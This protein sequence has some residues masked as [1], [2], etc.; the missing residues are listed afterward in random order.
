MG[1][2]RDL[3]E[4]KSPE[5]VE[6][7][8]K[9]LKAMR[10]TLHEKKTTPRLKYDGNLDFL[11]LADVIYVLLEI[12]WGQTDEEKI[13]FI[14]EDPRRLSPKN[15]KFPT[16]AFQLEK[17]EP[18]VT[19]NRQTVERTPRERERKVIVNKNT[20]EKK[21]VRIDGQY[22]DSEVSFTVFGKSNLE[23]MYYSK[24]F[25][26]AMHEYKGLLMSHGVQNMWF[27]R[28]EVYENKSKEYLSARKITYHVRFE[29]LYEVRSSQ[30]EEIIVEAET[31]LGKL[32]K[33]GKLPS[34]N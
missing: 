12:I 13:N 22:I 20:G 9:D 32:R 6:L 25:M 8:Q 14:M 30:V 26:E 3:G 28:D 34:Q 31:V 4:L 5:I 24:K 7:G 29:K 17:Q 19:G 15:I 1:N 21:E 16:I 33:E 23:T 18:G 10:G 2:L 27:T 11:Q